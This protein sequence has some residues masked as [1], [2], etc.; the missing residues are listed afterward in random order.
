MRRTTAWTS[1]VFA[2]GMVPRAVVP[3]LRGLQRLTGRTAT[4]TTAD[5]LNT[6]V[7]DPR[8]RAVLAA[9]WGDYG[10][11]PG[12]SAFAVHSLIVAHYLDGAW[13][14]R[15][16]SA[17]V[18]RTFEKGIE[19]AGGA[20]RVA[21]EVT[22]ILVEDGAAVG[23][24]LLD[25]RGPV[26]R[27]RTV[28]APV[29]VSAVGAAPTFSRLLPTDGAIGRATADVRSTVAELGAG[30]SAVVAYLRLSADPRTLGVD[31]GNVWV[32][33]DLD[34][35]VTAAGGEELLAGRPRGVGV[36]VSFPSVKAGHEVHTA[37]I[38]S[39]VDADAFA[40]WADRPVGDRGVD[41]AALKR[42]VAAGMLALAETAVPGL[43]ELVEYTEVSTPLSVEHFTPIPPA[44]STGLLRVR[45]VSFP[46]RW[47]RAHRCATCSWP[48]RTPA[49]RGSSGR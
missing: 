13:F 14:S 15:D 28:R 31:G 47:G 30:P 38:I 2:Q 49:A 18:A 4:G 23:V 16:G 29:V 3:L 17:H 5:Y 8:L 1:A 44:P 35:D 19:S 25:R 26:V 36:Y 22:E 24:R 33:G 45:S 10:L 9:Q 12:R 27:E 11:P 42:R 32:Y 39:F 21:Q 6:R 40:P 7:R 34:H 20:V 37:E 46:G 41:Y 48:G 43:S